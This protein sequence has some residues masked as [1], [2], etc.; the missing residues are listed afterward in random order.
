MT[1]K[2]LIEKLKYYDED[3]PITFNDIM[4]FPIAN[5]K[6]FLRIEERMYATYPFTKNDTFPYLT[7]ILPEGE[8]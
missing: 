6:N 8:E 4:D 3:L 2:Q 7:F 1:V 5:D